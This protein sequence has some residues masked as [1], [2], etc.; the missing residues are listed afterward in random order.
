MK[1]FLRHIFLLLALFMATTNVWADCVIFSDNGSY[2]MMTSGSSSKSKEFTISNP[3]PCNQLVFT[4]KH[5]SSW[6]TGGVK[7]TITYSDGSTDEETKGNGTH[8]IN[9]NRKIVTKLHFKGTGTLKKTLSAITLTQASYVDAPQGFT[10]NTWPAGTDIVGHS[11]QKIAT[12]A[13]SDATFTWEL[14]NNTDNQFAASFSSTGATCTYGTSNITV[15]YLRTKPGNHSATLK[16][17]ASTGATYTIALSGV[18]GKYTPQAAKKMDVVMNESYNPSDIFD[19]Y[20]HANNVKNT[21]SDYTI[22][23]LD[24]TIANYVDG[25][26]VTNYQTG[27]ARFQLTREADTNFDALNT[28]ISVNVNPAGGCL[29]LD[30]P[31]EYSFTCSLLGE[32]KEYTPADFNGVPYQLSFEAETNN[33]DRVG[34][35]KVQQYVNGWQDVDE[36]NPNEGYDSYGP[37]ELSEQAT[38]IR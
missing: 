10:N 6:A 32:D 22:K 3:C 35:V 37:Y 17:T 29:V 4:N 25:K 14:L 36:I 13:W 27:T 21:I 7:V 19:V 23:A 2:E 31:N 12:I 26:I 24:P 1:Q 34:N 38:K 28:T 11:A 30:A 15:T 8:T 5:N 16:I 20:Y 9:L 18:T 33:N